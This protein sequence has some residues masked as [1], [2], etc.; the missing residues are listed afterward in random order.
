MDKL[1]EVQ[2]RKANEQIRS[3]GWAVGPS[4]ACEEWRSAVHAEVRGSGLQIRTGESVGGTD[5]SDGQTHPWAITVQGYQV[6]H[7]K[8][9]GVD[10]ATLGSMV[11]SAEAGRLKASRD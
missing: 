4:V 11:V 10:L 5:A 2:A 8:M 1:V 7:T 3:L 9:G 6:M